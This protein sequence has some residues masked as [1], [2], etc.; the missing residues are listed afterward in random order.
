MS[1]WNEFQYLYKYILNEEILK[2]D[3]WNI[4]N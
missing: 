3:E 2:M 1:Y 4:H